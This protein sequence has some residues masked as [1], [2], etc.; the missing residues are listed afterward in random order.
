MSTAQLS[1]AA[2][3]FQYILRRTTKKMRFLFA[4]VVRS[5]L[6][7]SFGAVGT[8]SLAPAFPKIA[9]QLSDVSS[10][11]WLKFFGTSSVSVWSRGDLSLASN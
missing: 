5:V 8:W 1:A 3:T 4:N 6:G 7:R 10:L 2:K 9:A 11:F